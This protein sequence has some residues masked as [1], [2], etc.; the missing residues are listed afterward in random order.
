M[1][2]VFV[3]G[4]AGGANDW[5]YQIS[6]ETRC[7]D[8]V[9]SRRSLFRT[10][11]RKQNVLFAFVKYRNI[12][13]EKKLLSTECPSLE[14]LQLADNTPDFPEISPVIDDS[15]NNRGCIRKNDSKV[16]NVHQSDKSLPWRMVF[17]Q[18]ICSFSLLL[19]ALSYALDSWSEAQGG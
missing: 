4:G 2:V 8:D 17:F 14:N 5:M 1:E 13:S 10:Y 12:L 19:R 11:L 15:G 16:P 18:Q 9:D 7:C 3:G 6:K